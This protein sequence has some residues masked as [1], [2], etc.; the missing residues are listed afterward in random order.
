MPERIIFEHIEATRNTNVQGSIGQ[1]WPLEQQLFFPLIGIKA[2]HMAFSIGKNSLATV[3]RIITPPVVERI[4]SHQTPVFATFAMQLTCGKSSFSQQIVQRHFYIRMLRSIQSTTQSPHQFRQIATG[5]FGSGQQF[6]GPHHSIIPHGS[7]LH[8]NMLPQHGNIFQLQH[9]IQAVFHDRISQPRCNIFDGSTLA[10]HLLHLGVHKH[11]ATGAQITRMLSLASQT[12]E[13]GRTITQIFGKS[14]DERPTTRR[15][16]LIDFNAIN[17]PIGDK[18]GLHVLSANI[19]DKRYLFIEVSGSHIVGNRLHYARMETKS[20]FDQVFPITGGT[21]AFN[22][23]AGP[24]SI[25]VFFQKPQTFF[26]RTAGIP[27]VIHIIGIIDAGLCIRHH[28][29]GSGRT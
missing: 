12:G 25:T 27:V 16:S 5:H 19:K 29:L 20:R 8:E 14:L 6:N 24:A 28:N 23:Q 17:N 10:Q 21:A 1:D 2:K 26:H 9:L 18:D 11:R 4:S 15:T 3:S 7:S 22:V 13:I